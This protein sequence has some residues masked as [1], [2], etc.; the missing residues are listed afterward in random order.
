MAAYR[1]ICD[2]PLI[3][4]ATHGQLGHLRLPSAWLYGYSR[5]VRAEEF[6]LAVRKLPFGKV[7][8]E[9]RYIFCPRHGVDTVPPELAAEIDR[10]ATA[11]RIKD[12]VDDWNLLKFHTREHAITF[13]A[14]PDFDTNP[15]PALASATKINLR[16]GTI[17]RTDFRQRANP[18]I[19]HRKETFLPPDDPRRGEFAALTR[20][21]EEYGL[22]REPSKIGL[23]VHWQTLLARLGLAYEGH[24]LVS[25][26]AHENANKAGERSGHEVEVARHRTAIKRYD[27]SRPVKR[28]LERGLLRK[29]DTFFDYGCGHGMDV[30]GLTSM[31]YQAAGWDP[32]FRPSAPKTPASVVNLGFVLNVIEYPEER[33]ATLRDAFVL[34]ERLL[35][36]STMAAGQENSAHTKTFGDGFLTKTNTFQKFFAPGELESL[37][38]QA[39]DAEAMTLELGMC[40][41]FRHPEDAEAFEAA[42]NRRRIDWSEIGAQLKFSTPASRERRNLDRYEL[43][44]GLF[45]EFWQAASELGRVP[46]PGEFDKLDDLKKSAGGI[47]RALALTLSHHGEA[48]WQKIR[49]AR[50]ED[51]LVYVAMTHFRHRF[52]QREIPLRTRNDIRAFFGDF[53]TAQTRARELLF[54]AG[55]PGEIELAC[56]IVTCGWQDAD[57]LIIHRSLFQELPPLLRVYV[58]CAAQRYG[59]PAQA[60]LI[61][62]HKHSRKI[63][64]QHYDDFDGKPLPELKTRIKVNL[65]N[66]FVEVFDHAA[67]PKIQLL[68]FKERFVGT[69]YPGRA[70]MEKFS[71]KL[72][73]LG[74]DEM[75]IGYGPDKQSFADILKQN[76]LSE[77]LKVLRSTSSQIPAKCA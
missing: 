59:D 27:L 10:A 66:L 64:F 60:D 42:R 68:F 38:E 28:L 63:T 58:Q 34:S 29:D 31:G 33:A 50:T 69:E 7:L 61:K 71:V 53:A 70:A 55:D 39:L 48:L 17:V 41:I 73:K 75:T 74:F 45:E 3:A 5:G 1:P 40:V 25:V 32:A 11:A 52:R 4:G 6:I 37:I 19:L 36:V 57:A 54:A 72:R 46:K 14:Y 65:R 24:R 16:T 30:E 21:E 35:L 9:A 23:R 77:K 67:G 47:N 13:L 76:G 15:H 2:W 44:R 62:I 20:Q 49:A 51:L 56:E 8:P 18:P 22:Y 43:H 26:R 12:G